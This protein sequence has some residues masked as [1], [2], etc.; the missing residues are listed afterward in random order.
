M[1][2]WHL[3]YEPNC[4]PFVLTDIWE[5]QAA[6]MDSGGGGG[7]PVPH[8]VTTVTVIMGHHSLIAE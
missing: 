2:V 7:G 1:Q 4:H 5:S 6:C 3:F 8:P